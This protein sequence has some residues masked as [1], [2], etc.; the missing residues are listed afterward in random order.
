MI[1]DDDKSKN[2][3]DRLLPPK[4]MSHLFENEYI[5][6]HTMNVDAKTFEI[7]TAV[8][9]QTGK[10]RPRVL[11][12]FVETAYYQYAKQAETQGVN[13]EKPSTGRHKGARKKRDV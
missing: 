9:E 11:A 6:Q 12:A 7:I 2:A 3:I 13:P 10:S 8:S 1:S 4:K 5:R